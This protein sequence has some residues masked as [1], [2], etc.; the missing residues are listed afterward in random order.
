MNETLYHEDD[1]LKEL[2]ALCLRSNALI[3][4]LNKCSDDVKN[5]HFKLYCTSIYCSHLWTDYKKSTYSKIHVAVF[6]KF[7]LPPRSSARLMFVTNDVYNF[8]SI[9]KS[10]VYC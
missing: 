2:G 3:R 1:I 4:T 9:I 10:K 5:E 6:K 8:E 7:L